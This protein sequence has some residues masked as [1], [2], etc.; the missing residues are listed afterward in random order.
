MELTTSGTIAV[1]NKNLSLPGI[2][3]LSGLNGERGNYGYGDSPVTKFSPDFAPG[4]EAALYEED[5]Y[6]KCCRKKLRH[7]Y[8]KHTRMIHISST[9]R[10]LNNFLNNNF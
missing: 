9:A 1:N 7:D 2:A 3:R 10:F 6:R 4:Y 8:R 5:C